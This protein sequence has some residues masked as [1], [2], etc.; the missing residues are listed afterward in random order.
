MKWMDI[1]S[2][3]AKMDIL[4]SDVNKSVAEIAV[5]TRPRT[6]QFVIHSMETVALAAKK[7]F[8]VRCAI[9]SANPYVKTNC[10]TERVV[11]SNVDLNSLEVVG[12]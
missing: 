4:E 1:V 10:V 5:P 8:T 6:N 12:K 9:V 3:A 7:N 2:S 11:V